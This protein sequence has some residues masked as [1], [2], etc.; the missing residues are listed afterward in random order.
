MLS[1]IGAS[2]PSPTTPRTAE[3]LSKGITYIFLSG[4]QTKGKKVYAC[5]RAWKLLQNQQEHK[6][7]SFV[8]PVRGGRA[9]A[10]YTIGASFKMCGF[11][12]LCD[13][14]PIAPA[15]RKLPQCHSGWCSSFSYQMRYSSG[16]II[17][18]CLRMKAAFHASSVLSNGCHPIRS[19]LGNQDRR[20]E[21][22]VKNRF[23]TASE[24]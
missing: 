17:Y 3:A 11:T 10:H 9:L 15:F 14:P 1:A 6:P 23:S 22:G 8:C 16:Y 21:E 4:L 20:R 7:V 18:V 19:N 13:G 2:T 24:L 5:R 12:G